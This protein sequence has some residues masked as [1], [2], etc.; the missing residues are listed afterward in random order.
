MHLEGSGCYG[1]NGADD[2]ALDAALLGRA[3]AGRPV[4]LQWMRDDEFGWEPYGSAMLAR[5]KA[6]LDANG[7]VV[8][9]VYEVW[10]NTHSTRPAAPGADNNLLASW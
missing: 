4:R 9:W 8:D 7:R 5:A 1:H 2:V 10:S 3:V 6:S